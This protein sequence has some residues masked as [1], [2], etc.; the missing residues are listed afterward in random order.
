MLGRALGALERAV[1]E[2]A[3]LPASA[4]TAIA[5]GPAVIAGLVFFQSRALVAL[6]LALAVGGLL[7]VL[8]WRLKLPMTT[9]P[10]VAAVIAVALFGPATPPAW[11]AAAAVI[12][13]GLDL[14][15]QRFLPGMRVEAGL[16]AYAIAFLIS[17][18][19]ITAYLQPGSL[20]PL[21]EPIQLWNAFGAGSAA[22]IDPVRLYVGNVPGPL[23]ATSLLAVVIGAA[24]FWYAHRLSLVVLVAFAAGVTIPV[25]LQHWNLGFHL[26]SGPA[27]FVVALVLAD[28][29]ALP[30]SRAARPLLGLAAGVIAVALRTRG[31]G[32]E[33]TFLVVVALQVAV[34]AVEG[35]DWLVQNRRLVGQRLHVAQVRVMT[36]FRAA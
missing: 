34:A 6:A 3:T 23:F 10:A 16:I 22:P 31:A 5:I 20:R 26:D 14:L 35:I 18:A 36:R 29:A 4:V 25:A 21:A 17:R 27:W 32:I 15:R 1:F 12:A 13:G 24:W 19:T 28:R 8:G 30:A 2:P 33:A 11:L 9:S 7:H